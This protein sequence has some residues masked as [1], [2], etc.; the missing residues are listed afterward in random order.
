MQ[1]FV[2][3]LLSL[4]CIVHAFAIEPPGHYECKLVRTVSNDLY[5]IYL[6]AHLHVID[7]KRALEPIFLREE[8]AIAVDDATFSFFSN[9]EDFNP[10]NPSRFEVILPLLRECTPHYAVMD[11][12]KYLLVMSDDRVISTDYRLEDSPYHLLTLVTNFLYAMQ[13][14]YDFLFVKVDSDSQEEFTKNRESRYRAK[15]RTISH[16]VEAIFSANISRSGGVNFTQYDTIVYLDSRIYFNPSYRTQSISDFI[17]I[18]EFRSLRNRSLS[19]LR[20]AP[21]VAIDEARVLFL[22]INSGISIV[23]W[24]DAAKN[25]SNPWKFTLNAMQ[26]AGSPGVYL[27]AEKSTSFPC[28]T[29]LCKYSVMTA[30][31]RSRS[32]VRE[33]IRDAEDVIRNKLLNKLTKHAEVWRCLN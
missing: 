24:W 9:D 11:R 6:G 15:T 14:N 5:F 32:S 7:P 3:G 4:L 30:A 22:N 33:D 19:V 18:W 12:R 28:G 8:D 2:R 23:D 20:S 31:E 17:N 27:D 13:H 29:W 16:I 1:R 10:G 26:I 25:S 21:V